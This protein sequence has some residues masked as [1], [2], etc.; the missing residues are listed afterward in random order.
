MLTKPMVENAAITGNFLLEGLQQLAE[1]HGSKIG[2][3]RGSGTFCAVSVN[4]TRTRDAMIEGLRAHGVESGGSGAYTI[5]LR[6]SMMF[7]PQHA[8][9][10][11]TIFDK[12]IEETEIVGEPSEWNTNDPRN[13]VDIDTGKQGK[14]HSMS[15][16]RSPMNMP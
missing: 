1:K 16:N 14:F 8:A 2:R 7:M 12:V 11:L 10:F 4:N 6:P 15:V 9:E 5:R 13:I 3:A